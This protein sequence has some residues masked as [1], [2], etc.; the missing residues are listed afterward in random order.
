MFKVS[1]LN[2]SVKEGAYQESLRGQYEC[3]G[4]EAE[5]VKSSE[6][7]SGQEPPRGVSTTT[8]CGVNYQPPAVI[9]EAA[10][11]GT[12]SS[13]QQQPATDNGVKRR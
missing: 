10:Q 8:E 3:G 4:R 9:K 1:E 13:S 6:G 11:W 12:P 5:S 2:N 7:K